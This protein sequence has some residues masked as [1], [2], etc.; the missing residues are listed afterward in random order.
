MNKQ[1]ILDPFQNVSASG[2]AICDMNKLLGTVLE[3]LTFVLGGTFTLSMI[4]LIQLKANAKV[5]WESTGSNV[6]ATNLFNGATNSATA[7]KIDFMDRKAVTV[8]ARQ[9]GTIDLSL[10]S[11]ITNLRLEVTIAGA[12]GPTLAGLA[13]VSPPTNDQNEAGIRWLMARRH[14]ATYVVPAAGMF[15]LPIPHID[16]AGGGSSY[17]RIYL[18]SANLT[19][20]KTVRDGVTEHDLQNVTFIQQ[21][22]I[23]NF[24][25]PQASLTVFDPVQTG[26]L[27]GNTWDTKKGLVGSAQFYG[28][29]SAGE[30]IT[31]ETEELLT[32]KDY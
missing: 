1:I 7:F 5:I 6:N 32:L 20:M 18:F 28:T 26:T 17:R 25:T 19:A 9:A 14:R 31:I 30:T 16:P 12:T 4:T 2:V 22:Q 21:P 13:D 29:F 11:G 8:N 24:K 23:D 27:L 15:A 10:G 3:K